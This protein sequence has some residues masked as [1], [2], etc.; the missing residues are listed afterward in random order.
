MH[1]CGFSLAHRRRTSN[2]NATQTPVSPAT[3]HLWQIDFWSCSANTAIN[4]CQDD[5][6]EYT[7]D[8]PAMQGFLATTV[9]LARAARTRAG[10]YNFRFDAVCAEIALHGACFDRCR[11]SKRA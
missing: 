1:T 5:S 6:T 2:P 4:C 9:A 11:P 3:Y 10:S 7:D 8:V